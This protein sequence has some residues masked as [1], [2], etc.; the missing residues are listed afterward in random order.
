M[1]RLNCKLLLGIVAGLALTAWPQRAAADT[2]SVDVF[3]AVSPNPF[4]SPS[5]SGWANNAIFALEN[6]LSSNGNPNSPT[7]YTQTNAVTT[8][9][10]IATGFPSWHGHANPGQ[11]FGPAY[12]NELGNFLTF[13]AVVRSNHDGPLD[14]FTL[15]NVSITITDPHGNLGYTDNLAGTSFGVSPTSIKVGSTDGTAQD[16]NSG[17]DTTPTMALW[18]TGFGTAYAVDSSDPG[19]TDQDKINNLLL[20]LLAEG[21]PFTITAQYT[22]VD[23]NGDTSTGSASVTVTPAVPIA[24]VVPEPA[25]LLLWGGAILSAAA[26]VRRRRRRETA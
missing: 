10:V 20:Q 24:G 17:G 13:G 11:V 23:S 8:A 1:S 6:G 21:G 19:A 22:V 25:S 14:T 2:F 12:A 26:A 16:I 9:D 4:G 3:P 5:F 7:F 18:Y 15:Q